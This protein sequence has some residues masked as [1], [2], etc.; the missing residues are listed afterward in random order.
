[1]INKKQWIIGFPSRPAIKGGPGS[2]QERFERH[3]KALGWQIVYPDNKITPDIIIVNGSTKHIWWLLKAKLKRSAIIYRLGGI[4]W[5]YKHKPEIS[6]IKKFL[7]SLKLRLISFTQRIFGNAIIYQS[8]FSKKWLLKLKQ[9][10]N[11]KNISII[12]NGVDI[13]LFKP[14]IPISSTKSKL[15]LI[16]VEGNLDYTPYFIE[17]INSL[18]CMLIDKGTLQGIKLYGDFENPANRKR[19][20]PSISSNGLISKNEIHKV[21]RDSIYLSLDI[22]PGCPNSLLEALASGIP[23]VGFDTGSLIELV[24]PEA[25]VIVPYGGDPWNLDYPDVDALVQ[26][27]IKVSDN[28]EEFSRNARKIAEEKYSLDIMMAKYMKIILHLVK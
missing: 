21:Y 22:N 7:I 20:N 11:L 4:N 25:G 15:S 16:C 17:L 2:F 9:S 19:L 8:E 28:Y 3:I 23:V 24:P 13:N 10:A 5:L 27:I 18:Q 14:T 6:K 1:M 26:A 12:F